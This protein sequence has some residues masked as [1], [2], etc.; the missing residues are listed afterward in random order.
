MNKTEINKYVSVHVRYQV[1]WYASA[2]QAESGS[3][4]MV[5]REQ[6]VSG[7]WKREWKGKWEGFP[8]QGHGT[9]NDIDMISMLSNAHEEVVR[10]DIAMNEVS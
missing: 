4:A 5:G 10:F 1:T 8:L 2:A 3:E 9:I 6:K 7:R